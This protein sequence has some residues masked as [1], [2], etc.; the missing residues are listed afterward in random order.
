MSAT[1]QRFIEEA[2]QFAD[3]MERGEPLALD[4]RYLADAHGPRCAVGHVLVRAGADAA[5]L[6][7]ETD[8]GAV[9]GVVTGRSYDRRIDRALASV[10][11][12][13]DAYVYGVPTEEGTSVATAA[14]VASRLREAASVI[15]AVL[16]SET[17]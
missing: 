9:F 16:E 3:E 5:E 8:P 2:R 13:N 17:P 7:N 12:T 10:A 15:A 1:P 11:E 14:D 4:A 6:V